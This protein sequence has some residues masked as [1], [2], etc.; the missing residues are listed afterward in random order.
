MGICY[1]LNWLVTLPLE[2]TAASITL[3]FWEGS[4]KI[5]PGVWVAIFWVAIVLINL[6]G[7][8]AYGEAEVVFSTIKVLAVSSPTTF[9]SHR[10]VDQ[11]V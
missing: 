8:K 4:A 3:S 11:A 2:L 5:N 10:E 7:V 6:T 9:S 1:S